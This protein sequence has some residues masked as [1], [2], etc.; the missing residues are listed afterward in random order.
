MEGIELNWPCKVDVDFLSAWI[1]WESSV[2]KGTIS[3]KTEAHGSQDQEKNL[4][5]TEVGNLWESID[6]QITDNQFRNTEQQVKNQAKKQTS[7][8][9]WVLDNRTSSVSN[10]LV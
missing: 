8:Q 5:C 6:K 7:E 10:M 9:L 4:G 1:T 3:S 2:T